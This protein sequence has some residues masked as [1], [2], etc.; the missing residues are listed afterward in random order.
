MST[1]T[2]YSNAFAGI[3]GSASGFDSAQPVVNVIDLPEGCMMMDPN[4]SWAVRL[5]SFK[6]HA[7]ETLLMVLRDNAALSTQSD[8]PLLRR[9]Q[10]YD[11]SAQKDAGLAHDIDVGVAALDALA[12][13]LTRRRYTEIMERSMRRSL[14]TQ[15]QHTP[16]IRRM[17]VG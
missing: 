5:R 16:L 2:A 17:M 6:A 7:A 11:E 1:A 12:H 10:S 8:T 13:K 14:L 3:H 4:G 15:S 9:L